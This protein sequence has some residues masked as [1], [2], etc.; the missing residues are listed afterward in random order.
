MQLYT[1]AENS[2]AVQNFYSVHVMSYCQGTLSS[3]EPGAPG[4]SRNVTE[5]SKQTILFAFDP[6]QAWPEEI[7]QGPELSWP[8]V[9][10]DDF[11]AFRVTSQAMAVLYIIGVGATGFALF[12][13]ASMFITRKTQ[14]GLFEFGFLVVGDDLLSGWGVGHD[15]LNPD[16]SSVLSASV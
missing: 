14:S 4:V 13:R 9:I 11:R 15:R 5:C 7:T 16:H 12:A 1:P 8:R 6:T 3:A 2:E 10:S